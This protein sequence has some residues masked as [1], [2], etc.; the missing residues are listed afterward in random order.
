MLITISNKA[1]LWLAW[2][3][4]ETYPNSVT[5]EY[6]LWWMWL[7]ELPWLTKPFL[8]EAKRNHGSRQKRNLIINKQ[9]Q[10]EKRKNMNVQIND[11]MEPIGS[12]KAHEILDGILG[13]NRKVTA[14]EIRTLDYSRR[15]IPETEEEFCQTTEQVGDE[16]NPVSN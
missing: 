16:S 6:K 8:T 4:R 9:E 13:G 1:W 12:A 11:T 3:R 5:A 14:E 10:E 2:G 15:V 7:K